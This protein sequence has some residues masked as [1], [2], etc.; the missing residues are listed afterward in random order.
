[1]IVAKKR[2]NWSWSAL[3][4]CVIWICILLPATDVAASE[5]SATSS[6]RY[7][8]SAPPPGAGYL[9]QTT[10]DRLR[11]S[12]P[13]VKSHS[14]VRPG[15]VYQIN[16]TFYVN[17]KPIRFWGVNM[18]W[19]GPWK[20]GGDTHKSLTHEDVDDFVARLRALGFN[21]VRIFPP[22]SF[23]FGNLQNG[24][25]SGYAKSDGSLVDKFDY[26][27]FRLK[28]E[29]MYVYMSLNLFGPKSD[30]MDPLFQGPPDE[31]EAWKT[32]SQ[33]YGWPNVIDKA[34]LVDK[35]WEHIKI[36]NVLRVLRHYNKW[37]EK[38]YYED[39]V[40][41]L[42]ELNNEV[43]FPERILGGEL[44]SPVT[45]KKSSG[46]PAYFEEQFQ[47][48]WN[49]YLVQKY[50]G[51]LALPEG[52][53]KSG[54]SLTDGSVKLAP[55]LGDKD[56]V[57]ERGRDFAQ[58]VLGHCNSVYDKLFDT[59]RGM[60]PPGVGASVVPINV[61]SISGNGDS[62]ANAFVTAR[63]GFNSGNGYQHHHYRLRNDGKHP[64]YPYVSM[65][66]L[67]P[68]P[69]GLSLDEY[70]Q[71]NSN[72]EIGRIRGQPFVM[73]EGMT[74]TPNIF[75]AEYFVDQAVLGSWQNHGGYFFYQYS[76][77]GHADDSMWYR[78]PLIY[79]NEDE[80]GTSQGFARDEVMLSVA[81]AV[82]AAFRNFAI[83]SAPNPTRFRVRRRR[84]LQSGLA[85]PRCRRR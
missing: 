59:I 60:A 40:F 66:S 21:A 30:E 1:M 82:G 81:W 84:D 20:Q 9:A 45:G 34:F 52:Y 61:D 19:G 3:Q 41:A 16:G 75:K 43:R 31:L 74:M 13:F 63:G 62:I 68:E 22:S 28:Q 32:A 70:H 4:R 77:R 2:R 85:R 17:A 57:A 69:H 72:M 78:G 64:D 46:M 10:T 47:A 42:F 53:L 25:D 15:F 23:F 27:L 56:Y 48:L 39:E 50:G 38:H 7:G 5:S 26:F 36:Q 76:I 29:G 58:F 33:Q 35:T 12:S 37:T 14:D 83:K 44:E 80:W 54:E 11:T 55:A 67:P 49:S 18:G 65:L 73:Y 79:S 51:E 24:Q 8:D 6:A 71:K